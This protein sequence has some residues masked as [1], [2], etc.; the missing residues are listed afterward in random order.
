MHI[1]FSR[2]VLPFLSVIFLPG[3]AFSDNHFDE[4]V[5]VFGRDIQQHGH[6]KSSSEGV[7]G[8]ADLLVRP[9]VRVAEMLEAVPGMVAVQHS[10]SGKA[11][12]YFLRGFNLD[13]GTDFS[14]YVDGVPWNLRS[15]GHGQG[16]LD[17]NGL[18][19]ESV[20]T[21]EYR[22]GTYRA[23]VGDFSIAASSF[24]RTIDRFDNR[25]LSLESG[26]RGWTRISGGGSK[27]I[28]DG[29][30]TGLGEYKSYDGP[31]QT[32][33]GLEHFSFWGKYFTPIEL[34]ELR[35]SLS[36]YEGDWH[37]TEQIPERVIGSSVCPNSFCAIDPSANGNTSRWIATASIES[38]DW[39]GSAYLQNYDWYM[40]SNPTYDYQINQF[41]KRTTL[42]GRFDQI[43]YNST[44]LT[45][46]V[47]YEIRHDNI[48]PVGLD[49]YKDGKFIKKIGDN[50]IK[51]TS[52]GAY[53]EATWYP[54]ERM[55][56]LSG[57][58]ADYFD[59]DVSAK[60]PTSFSGNKE[61]SLVSPKFG[62]AYEVNSQIEL[63][64]SW[65]KGFHSN[66]ARGV[67][68]SIDPVP[69]LSPGIGKEI[70]SRFE[71]DDLKFTATYWWLN[72]DSELIFVG[73]SNSVEAKGGSN[74][75]GYELSMFWQPTDWLGIDAVYTD[76]DAFYK[77]I[78]EGRYI[79]GSL[80]QSAQFGISAIKNN[81][82]LSLRYRYMGPYALLPTNLHRAKEKGT[83]SL[84]GAYTLDQLTIYADLIN[85]L[86][87]KNK[88][89]VYY[90]PAYV[91]GFDPMNQTSE[92]INC[93]AVDCRMSRITEPRTLRVGAKW[94]FK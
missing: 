27:E 55:R 47:G 74:R 71:F 42:G 25:F 9:M 92:T 83:L 31:W 36:G 32:K 57:I 1:L 22:K 41:D 94:N 59:F 54:V 21:I 39:V 79:E 23:D 10:G 17:V 86:D 8:G 49:N 69:G 33:E 14:T 63:Y 68:N 48:G 65:G 88:D 5:Y 93:D 62:L 44:G 72:L 53:I 13:H 85:V 26:E 12:Q 87:D 6:A 51:E 89:I 37:P 75:E 66:D 82:E 35:I 60:T 50:K 61:D 30:L 84:R 38:D 24:I 4:E 2:V 70:G 20:N 45:L 15:H 16:Y 40:T 76:S 56:V 11:N 18:L 80:E 46:D 3:L 73:D 7:V 90:Y 43:L 64:A 52:I 78:S 19:P 28:G 29:V 34:G 77:D 58:R 67:V 81:W 91:D